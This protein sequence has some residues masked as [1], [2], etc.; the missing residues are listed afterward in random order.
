MLS[1]TLQERLKDLNT[2]FFS[3]TMVLVFLLCEI[4]PVLAALDKDLLVMLSMNDADLTNGTYRI[5]DEK[6]MPQI[7]TDRESTLT[8][9]NEM[10]SDLL[11]TRGSGLAHAHS[12]SF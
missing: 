3:V 2:D 6:L 9:L 11:A 12:S 1:A 7:G 4:W 10:G 8:D 5:I